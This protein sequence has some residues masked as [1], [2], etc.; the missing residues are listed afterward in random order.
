MPFLHRDSN[1]MWTVLNGPIGSG[2]MD[3]L[4]GAGLV[5][6]TWYDSGSRNFYTNVLLSTVD[7]FP[8]VRIRMMD[9]PLMM[10][11]TSALGAS[12][13]A[14]GLGDVYSAL[15]TGLIDG[16]ENNVIAYESWS[17]YEV[18]PYLLMSGHLRIPE[19]MVA[20]GQVFNR[21]S[22]EDQEII[23][24]SA[25][26]AQLYQRAIWIEREVTAMDMV[27]QHPDVVVTEL[28]PAEWQR[29][30]DAMAPVHAEFG[31]GSE[32]LIE[33]IVNTS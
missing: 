32:A 19:L 15:Q 22:A 7:D 8:G 21:L 27:M 14:M 5:G 10:S 33:Q 9:N 30:A 13:I 3:D 17:H 31:A 26:D 29:F 2:L 23:M 18:A 4:E 1:H 24:Q 6:L 20:S 16:A 25:H 12:G 28:S 11:I